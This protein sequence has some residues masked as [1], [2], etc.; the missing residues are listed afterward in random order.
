MENSF[1]QKWGEKRDHGYILNEFN[2]IKKRSG[3]DIFDFIKIFNKLYKNHPAEIKPPQFDAW[4]VFVG[5]FDSKFGFTLR[6]RKS[7]TLDQI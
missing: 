7:P 6:E 3:E 4:V 1:M 5:A 2:A